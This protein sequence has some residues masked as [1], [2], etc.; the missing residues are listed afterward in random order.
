MSANLPPLPRGRRM[1]SGVINGK[2]IE[3]FMHDDAAML[4]YATKAVAAQAAELEAL[5]ADAERYR[6]LRDGC[7]DKLSE[8]TRIAADC[9]GMEWD[10]AIDAARAALKEQT[11]NV[12]AK[13]ETTAPAKN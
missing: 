5:R 2:L 3:L 7:D 12:G 13:L 4:A 1:G 9:Y 6:W 11:P 8:A 10:A